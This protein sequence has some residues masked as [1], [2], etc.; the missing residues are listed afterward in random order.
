MIPHLFPVNSPLIF[1]HI[2]HSFP[3]YSLPNPTS[4]SRHF[5]VIP[6]DSALILLSFPVDSTAIFVPFSITRF[7]VPFSKIAL[8]FCWPAWSSYY[9]SLIIIIIIIIMIGPRRQTDVLL[10]VVNV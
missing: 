3:V 7:S 9:F 8:W 6:L 5:P 4:F 1:S 2:A 10:L